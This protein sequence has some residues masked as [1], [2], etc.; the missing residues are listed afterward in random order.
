MVLLYLEEIVEHLY[1]DYSPGYNS[2]IKNCVNY[3]SLA[4]WDKQDFTHWGI[5]GCSDGSFSSNGFVYNCLN[6]GTIT[7]NGTATGEL[8]IEGIAGY[9]EKVIIG[10]CVSSGKISVNKTRDNRIGS[11]EGH[12][13]LVSHANYCYYTSDLSGYSKLSG[14]SN[15]DSTTS[16]LNETISIGSYTGNSHWRSQYLC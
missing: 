9:T 11:I 13:S 4:H 10:N 14:S 5:I 12:V 15:Y 7:H 3:G 1:S 16:E 8:N 6:N 2:T